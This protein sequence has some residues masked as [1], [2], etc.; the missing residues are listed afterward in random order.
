[1]KLLVSALEPS[2]NLH[3]KEL[4]G[5][6]A[7]VEIAGIF[8]E[9]LGDPLYSSREFGVMGFLDILP[10][11]FKAK[12][13]IKE[14]VF[15]AKD[16]D[17]VLLMDSSAFNLPLAKAIKKRYPN[18]Q[19][20]YYILPQAW[21]WR[22]GRIKL[23]EEYCDYLASILPFE[24]AFYTKAEFVGN[25]L[26][27]EIKRFKEEVGHSGAV[28]FLPGSRKGEIKAL[29]GVF[30]EVAALIKGRKLLVV[31]SHFSDEEII[32]IYGKDLPFEIVR[33]THEALYE[34]DFAFV[35][36]GTATLEAALIGTPF[37]LVY[38]AKRL[39]FFIARMFIK[40]KYVGLANLILDF[41]GYPPLHPELL[42]DEVNW[43]NLLKYYRE[44][45][46]KAFLEGSRRLRELLRGGSA[47]KVAAIIQGE[48]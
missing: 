30:K 22:R 19:I 27:D 11:I 28:A 38:R 34:S 18:K 48:I 25:P 3:L 20:I 6:L 2:A 4:L 46:R 1:M 21:A 31:P 47:K 39:D 32:H 5:H 17:K 29:M 16:V 42:Q 40:L 45:D 37:V 10:K 9:S 36:S 7:D 15:L 24:P 8:D 26:M 14:M 13:A 12:E 43:Q 44:L 41:F 23:L 35:C 33:N